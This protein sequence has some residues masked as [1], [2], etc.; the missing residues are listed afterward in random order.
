MSPRA[1]SYPRTLYLIAAFKLVKGLLLVAVGVGAHRY[2]HRNAALDVYQWANTF[3]VDSGNRYVHAL[4]KRFA[5]LD[6]KT[7][8]ELS[9][10]TFLY[11]ALF[12]TEGTGLLLRKR[13]A[14]YFTTIVTCSFIPLEVY[15]LVRRA[16][17]VKGIVLALNAAV[18]VYL[19]VDLRRRR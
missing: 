1:E 17:S 12:L 14:E 9:V 2:L 18:V 10:G 16:T 8:R 11:A 4:L 13:W 7:L 15:E 5:N 3:R 6:P 19:I